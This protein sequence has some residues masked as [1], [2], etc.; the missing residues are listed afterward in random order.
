MRCAILLL[1]FVV[2]PVGARPP[3]SVSCAGAD[4]SNLNTFIYVSVTGGDSDSC[5]KNPASACK[6][7]SQGIKNCKTNGCN[8]LVRYGVYG[9]VATTVRLADGVSLYGSCSFDGSDR[10]Y[11]STLLGRPAISA[12]GIN[13]P[14]MI[15]GFVI[16]G[17]SGGNPG[18]A[19]VAVT[20]AN[21]SGL[22]L[23]DD[24]LASGTGG[25]GE[26]GSAV[27]GDTGGSGKPPVANAGGAGGAACPANPPPGPI[28]KGG[29]G[30]DF[31]QLY[32]SG[33]FIRCK[34]DNNNYPASV[35]KNGENSGNVLGG[36]G[37]PRAG[38]G[39][40]CDGGRTAGN[41]PAGQ[42][43]RSGACGEQGGL[44][45]PDRKGSFAGTVWHPN[46]AGNGAAGEV[47]SG[48]GGGGSGGFGV[49]FPPTTDYHGYPGGGGGGGGCGG[50]GGTG[51]QQGGASVPLV[52]VNSSIAG[53][54]NQTVIIPGPGGRGGDGAGGGKGGAGGP[55][56]NGKAGRQWYLSNAAC[57][58]YVP[59]LGGRGG[60]GGQGGAGGGGAG[61]NGGPSFA[62]ALVNS[63]LTL[64][65]AT[66]IYAAQPGAGG[67][68]GPGGQ[69]ASTQCKGADGQS[70]APGF[71]DNQNSI[72]RFASTWRR[73]SEEGQQ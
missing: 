17:E 14:T 30:A 24:V 51:G 60:R 47:G 54:T 2:H 28:G 4:L 6:T 40:F 10:K 49:N 66:T 70:G 32:S 12:D 53:F 43:G 58:G 29:Y 26:Q 48:A 25:A 65:S 31:Q 69:N 57:T 62:V 15:H 68:R 13:Q 18:E 33:C 7:I 44:A 3:A 72:V 36:T 46:R 11:R 67:V 1:S 41:G 42:D 35:G 8:V 34:C 55:G 20:V 73:E 71:F 27:A 37:G 5:G 39:C 59:G 56:A 38:P 64:G 22:R 16:Y 61:G 21:S 63:Q 45:N 52:L 19:S 50:G 23:S 9:S